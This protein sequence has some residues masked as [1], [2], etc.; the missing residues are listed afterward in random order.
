MSKLAAKLAEIM[1]EIDHVDKRGINEFHKYTYMKASDLAREVRGRLSSRGIIVLTLFSDPRYYTIP[2]REGVMQAVD[3]K[4]TMTFIDEGEQF[5]ISAMGSG[6]DRGDKAIY[7]AMTGAVKYALRNMFLVP[8]ESDPEADAKTD[9][10][11]EGALPGKKEPSARAET[12]VPKDWKFPELAG[13]FQRKGYIADVTPKMTKAK[14]PQA[15]KK[16]TASRAYTAFRFCY[17]LADA[18]QKHG[19]SVNCWNAGM[20][21][22]LTKWANENKLVEGTFEAEF[23][24]D[25]KQLF[26]GLM[27]LA[28]QLEKTD[29]PGLFPSGSKQEDQNLEEPF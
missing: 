12:S 24:A 29:A 17:D 19:P 25:G 2:V 11:T 9:E 13:R 4:V 3:V 10:A 28:I 8:D 7:K 16:A 20:G 6:S 23:G 15:G 27:D 14:P 21:A 5:Q 1:G 18:A 22:T 26:Y